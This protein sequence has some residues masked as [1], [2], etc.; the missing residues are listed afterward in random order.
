MK[1]V[2]EGW[3][4]AGRLSR[5]VGAIVRNSR[6]GYHRA[7][8]GYVEAETIPEF[9]EKARQCCSPAPD[10]AKATSTT[11]PSPAARTISQRQ[12]R[13][14]GVRSALRR[15]PRAELLTRNH[16]ADAALRRAQAKSGASRSAR[17]VAPN[18]KDVRWRPSAPPMIEQADRRRR[19]GWL[20][21][22]EPRRA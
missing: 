19:R 17:C 10:F 6:R 12:G 8:M 11:S 3:K 16:R 22:Q 9:Q 20:T 1:L 7:T 5:P 2:P 14:G 15:G 18:R 21:W 4:G 13:E